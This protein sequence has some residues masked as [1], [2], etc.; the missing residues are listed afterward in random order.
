[1]GEGIQFEPLPAERVEFTPP[2]QQ[3]PKN[4]GWLG[5]AFIRLLSLLIVGAAVYYSTAA[6]TIS[7]DNKRIN[8]IPSQPLL[9][10]SC[11][12]GGVN[13]TLSAGSGSN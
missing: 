1:M 8:A 6:P 3:E 9:F 12:T 4:R 2:V 10:G 11:C 13:S 7:S 5:I